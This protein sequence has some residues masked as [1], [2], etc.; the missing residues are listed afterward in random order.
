[1]KKAVLTTTVLTATLFAASAFAQMGPG[2]GMG[3][4]G[5]GKFGWNQDHTPGWTLMSSEERNA[6]QAQMG[7]VKTYDECKTTQDTHRQMMEGRAKEKG[8][9]FA[10]ASQNGCDAMKARGLIQ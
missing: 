2:G 8:L 10:P 7:A 1:M 6:W 4:G 3:Q 5:K 9:K